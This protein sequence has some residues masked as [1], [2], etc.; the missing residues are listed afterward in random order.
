MTKIES[1][2]KKY[3]LEACDMPNTV[4][5]VQ[6]CMKDIKEL[7]L[8]IKIFKFRWR[9]YAQKII[10]ENVG[11]YKSLLIGKNIKHNTNQPI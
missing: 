5:S 9:N 1:V 8:P 10:Q 11:K 3:L 7:S 6:G 4:L 2:T